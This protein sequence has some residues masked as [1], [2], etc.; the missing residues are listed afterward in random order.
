MASSE[1][2]HLPQEIQQ[3]RDR[4]E[5]LLTADFAR[6]SPGE[7]SFAE[8]D[9][10]KEDIARR[11]LDTC[12]DLAGISDLLG[13]TNVA[14]VAHQLSNALA[15]VEPLGTQID[16]LAKQIHENSFPTNRQALLREVPDK[17]RAAMTHLQPVA[18]EVRSR[19]NRRRLESASLSKM[20][21]ESEDQLRAITKAGQDADKALEA[22]RAG[23][24]KRVVQE[25]GDKFSALRD[26]LASRESAWFAAACLSAIALVSAVGFIVFFDTAFDAAGEWPVVVADLFRRVLAVSVPAAFLRI[27][28]GKYN[29]ERHLR[30]I[31]EHRTRVLE[32]YSVFEAAIGDDVESKNQLRMEVVRMIFNDPKTGYLGSEPGTDLN[33]SPVVN[34][35]EG[36]GSGRRSG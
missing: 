26:K 29:A 33:L 3:V 12:D 14:F 13:H 8:A 35:V 27:T 7:N 30:L 6:R 5:Q 4:A 1:A 18:T 17:A 34:L 23:A 20:R 31:Y 19:V 2:S 24:T 36:L 22:I 11:V 21:E 25:G 15:Q 16:K 32:Q 28:L 9:Q 10:A